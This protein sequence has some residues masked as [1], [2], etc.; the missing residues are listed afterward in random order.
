MQNSIYRYLPDMEHFVELVRSLPQA[1]LEFKPSPTAWSVHEIAV[2]LVDSEIVL[3]H[4]L[5]AI[6]SE[7]R[8]TFIA[9][10]QDAWARRLNYASL[11]VEHHL[12]A[13]L[14]LR[15]AFAPVLETVTEEDQHRIGVHNEDGEITA[16]MLIDKICVTHLES[17]VKQVQRNRDAFAAQK[18]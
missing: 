8:P 2:H 9:F 1:E 15:R 14:A 12:E 6:L 10:D 18:K 7:E 17:H 5:K 3:Q 13:L 11:D 16:R 4:R